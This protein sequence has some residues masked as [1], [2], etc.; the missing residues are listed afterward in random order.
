MKLQ[1][2]N[3]DQSIGL[4]KLLDARTEDLQKAKEKIDLLT[5]PPGGPR[6]GTYHEDGTMTLTVD[7]VKAWRKLAETNLEVI[8][9]LEP[10][11]DNGDPFILGSL[12]S[13]ALIML[14]G[15]K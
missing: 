15:A 12:L 9:F 6:G 14:R 11:V 2:C 10:G 3:C 5:D 1:P 4:Q 8:E 13:T 7:G